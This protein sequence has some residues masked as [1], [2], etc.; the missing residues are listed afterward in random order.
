MR[1]NAEECWA[2]LA[3]SEHGV[4]ATVHAGRGVDAVPVVFVVA[5]GPRIL[6][7]IDTVKPKST[8]RLRRLVNLEHDGRCVLLV[9][10]YRRDWSNLW[11]VRVHGVGTVDTSSPMSLFESFDAYREPGSIASMIS[12]TPREI[13]GW[14]SSSA[15]S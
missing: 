8:T 6:I 13:T 14:S 1:L 12:I 5:S 7:P 4:L 3:A 2:K 10:E 11:W 15:W 9:D